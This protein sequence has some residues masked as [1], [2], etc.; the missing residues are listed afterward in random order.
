MYSAPLIYTMFLAPWLGGA[1]RLG[2]VL[3]TCI[4]KY[5]HSTY[6]VLMYFGAMVVDVKVF[7][8]V[9]AV[10]G[11]DVQRLYHGKSILLVPHYCL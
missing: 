8:I 2:L 3:N 4:Q 5:I 11:F 1:I 7:T 10:V 6:L 9:V